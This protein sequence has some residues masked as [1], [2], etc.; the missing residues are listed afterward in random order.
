LDVEGHHRPLCITFVDVRKA[1][2]TVS[3][4]SMVLA[5]Q[6]IGFPPGLVAYISCLYAGG[7]TQIWVGHLLDS[8]IRPRRGIRQGYPLSPPLFC[9]V[10]DWV[11]SQLGL[12][13]QGG[14][15][16]NH[17]AFADDVALLSSTPE[18]M[19]RLLSELE[20]GLE[21]VGLYPNPAKSASLWIT[22]KGKEKKWYC[23]PH[24]FFSLGGKPVPTIDICGSYKY[25]GIK[26][27]V[28]R[29]N[30]Y[31]AKSRLEE[32]IRQLSKPPLKP[33]LVCTRGARPVS[34]DSS[35][36]VFQGPVDPS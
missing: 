8:C 20:C 21:E 6:R 3:H 7:V 33:H 4:E 35:G 11:L 9:T 16:M 30:T 1:F 24:A 31:I 32:S 25:L 36:E 23:D 14:V 27:G 12:E 19:K 18:A 2:E 28:S 34:R 5:D 10:M 17:I 15:R 29:K 13:L 26:T 22:V